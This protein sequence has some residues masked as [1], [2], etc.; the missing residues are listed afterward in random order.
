MEKIRQNID[1]IDQE[2]LNLLKERKELALKIGQI[3]QDEN[4]LFKQ[5]EREQTV[6]KDVEKSSKKLGLDPKFT[7]KL[8]K[9]IIK[10][11]LEEQAN[12][13]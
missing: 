11:S 5:P 9:L 12:Q 7:E 13:K 10:N 6:F 3:K 8:F 2:I 1:E 4:L